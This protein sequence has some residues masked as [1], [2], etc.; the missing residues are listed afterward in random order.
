MGIIPG[1]NRSGKMREFAAKES[2]GISDLAESGY[3]RF[4]LGA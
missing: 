3:G 2:K 4:R 1:K